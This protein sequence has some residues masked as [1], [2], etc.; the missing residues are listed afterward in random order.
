MSTVFV[1]L[2]SLLVEYLLDP[3]NDCHR[4]LVSQEGYAQDSWKLLVSANLFP[5]LLDPLPAPPSQVR[6][7]FP[8]LST[9]PDEV[10]SLLFSLAPCGLSFL[11]SD[12]LISHGLGF[13]CDD[14]NSDN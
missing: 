9:P 11:K 7:L 5:G 14:V 10:L 4:S 1:L 12:Q 13:H 3:S 8:C 2:K 6:L